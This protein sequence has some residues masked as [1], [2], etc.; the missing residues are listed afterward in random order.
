MTIYALALFA[1]IVGAILLFAALT[2]EGLSFRLRFSV[3]EYNRVIGPVSGLLILIPGLYM[4]RVQW[5]FAPWIIFGIAVWVLIASIGAAT[6]IAVMRKGGNP[7]S[8]ALLSWLVR[9]ALGAVV[10]FDMVVKP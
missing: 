4:A 5:G 10:I 7:G 9:I 3:A 2:V 8:W 1:H 6:G